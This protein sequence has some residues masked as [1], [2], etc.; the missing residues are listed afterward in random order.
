MNPSVCWGLR[1]VNIERFTGAIPARFHA[2]EDDS[3]PVRKEGAGLPSR[4]IRDVKIEDAQ[5]RPI[6]LNERGFPL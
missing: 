4:L 3:V 2:E 5:P 1:V 6:R